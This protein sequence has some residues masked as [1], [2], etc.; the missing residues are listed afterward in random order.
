MRV[1]VLRLDD[2]NHPPV[3]VADSLSTIVMER[4]LDILAILVLGAFFGFAVLRDQTPGWLLTS[5]A[6]GVA[7]LLLFGAVLLS[8]PPLI[9][10]L[11]RLSAHR[12]WQKALDFAE[13]LVA[14]LRTLLRQPA[15]AALVVA[16]SLYI[17]L[18]DALLVWLV[19]ASLRAAM[20]LAM[21][22]FVALTVDVLAAVPLT[23]GGVGQI[24]A[25][26][27]SLLALLP[28]PPFNVGVAVLV[29]RFISYWSFLIFAGLMT[30]AAG[31]GTLFKKWRVA[32]GEWRLL[33]S[34]FS[35][36]ATCLRHR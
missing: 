29:V 27:A 5:Y 14:D 9:G 1:G 30:M 12:L 24:D 32:S 19:I 23:P 20:P 13:R 18:C 4:A 33:T 17:W 6:V 7:L 36:Q 16:E 15:T 10:W 35:H 26:Y 2:R 22:A 11:R 28:H 31:F 3:P 25:A 8:V 21:A 34:R